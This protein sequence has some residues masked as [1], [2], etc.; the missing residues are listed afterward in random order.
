MQFLGFSNHEKG[1]P[2]LHLKLAAN[3]LQFIF[4]KW[5]ECCKKCIT[6]QGR[7]FK[8]ETVTEPPTRF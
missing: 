7:Y 5:V 3:S 2:R 8:K 6:C 4:E 1:A